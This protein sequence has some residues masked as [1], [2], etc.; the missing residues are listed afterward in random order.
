MLCLIW[1]PIWDHGEKCPNV[2][3]EKSDQEGLMSRKERYV[4]V[5]QWKSKWTWKFDLVCQIREQLRCERPLTI[6]LTWKPTISILTKKKNRKWVSCVTKIISFKGQWGPWY[7]Q[8]NKSMLKNL[9]S[10][11]IVL[12]TPA[13]CT[14][15][16]KECNVS[17]PVCQIYFPS[18]FD[19]RCFCAAFPAHVVDL[20]ANSIGNPELCR[21]FCFKRNPA[22]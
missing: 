21:S 16:K 19:K 14:F 7:V 22:P 3:E 6:S 18:E 13:S 1:H 8:S 2:Y 9:Q 20:A 10:R 17:H 11:T 5:W 12:P 4:W 15:A